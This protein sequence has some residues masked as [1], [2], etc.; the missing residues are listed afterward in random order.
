MIKLIASDMDGTLLD[1]NGVVPEETYDLIIR[2]KRAGI[3]FAVASGR[4][5]DTLCDFFDPIVNEVDYVASNGAQVFVNQKLIDC[6]TF[7]HAA[8]LRL[9]SVV[10]SHRNLHLAVF[11]RKMTYLM[12]NENHF[13]PELD[14]NL[15]N[16]VRAYELPAPDTGIVK[17]SIYCDD[18]LMDMAYILERELGG[19]FVFAP[20]GE[21]WIDVMQRGV[22]KATGIRQVMS[23]YGVAPSEVMAFGDAMNDYEILRLVGTSVAMANGR[24]AIK[25]IASKVIGTNAEHSV[26]RELE[27]VLKEHER[28]HSPR[29]AMTGGMAI[30]AI[31]EYGQYPGAVYSSI[32]S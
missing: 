3:R 6:E 13:M 32:A 25:Q 7:S 12:D 8:L 30:R 21:K 10:D 5:L 15:P 29:P 1:E 2:L 23:A 18:A 22:S 20:S 19:D 26:Q 27:A 28:L 14:K 4:R 17:A 11:D 9:C 16:P 31:R 24:S